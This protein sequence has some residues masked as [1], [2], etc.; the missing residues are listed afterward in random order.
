MIAVGI[1]VV[2]FGGH[3]LGIGL[4]VLGALVLFVG[5]LFPGSALL[6]VHVAALRV[7]VL[8]GVAHMVHAVFVFHDFHP[9]YVGKGSLRREKGD[10]A[11]NFLQFR[12][13]FIV[14]QIFVSDVKYF[15]N[16]F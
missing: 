4:H 5:S 10:Y 9:L 8:G 15:G 14:Q 3:V 11:G 7:A 16:G 6:A 2:L 1:L 12:V 13:S